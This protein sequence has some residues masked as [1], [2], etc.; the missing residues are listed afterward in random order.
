MQGNVYSAGKVFNTGSGMDIFTVKYSSS[1][2]ILWERTYNGPGN[3]NDIAHSIAV[4]KKGN[5][6]VGG[7]S[8]GLNTER[9]Y[10]LLKF[11]SQGDEQWVK[12]Y[13]GVTGSV[14]IISK[15]LIDQTGNPVV[16]GSSYELA[17]VSDIVT[18]K[19]D[20]DGNELW[21]SHFNGPA[22]GND[23]AND[24]KID[25][26][27]NIYVCGS[28]FGGVGINDF[29][30][31]KYN[32][33]G[34]EIWNRTYNG[35][36]NGNDNFTSLAI[37]ILGNVVITGSSVGS[38]T[39]IDFAT[40]KYSP[41]GDS[42]WTRR[43]N[44]PANSSHDEPKAIAMD[45]EG[46]VIITGTSVG[47]S[48][49]YDYLTVKY[50]SDGQELW[51]RRYHG[52]SSLAFDE[53]RSIV[54][55]NSGNSY[56]AGFSQGPAATDDMAIIKYDP[57]GNEMWVHRYSSAANRNDVANVV[58]LDNS[59][60]L[61]VSGF[62][63]GTASGN[64]FAVIKFS[65]LTGIGHNSIQ[66]P[67]S[68]SLSQNYPNPFNPSTSLDFTISN[69]GFVALKV[70]DVL[71]NEVSTMLNEFKHAGSY[72]TE[73]SGL[74]SGNQLPSGIYFYTLLVNGIRADTKRMMLLK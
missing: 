60:N 28:S 19:Y 8:K 11:N 49:S 35:P 46:N 17:T 32:I 3:A 65:L 59:G 72:K 37:D 21:R 41:L 74:T 15:V 31:I 14:D 34:V 52:L 48:T 40:V 24:M 9:D 42:L 12:R 5:V 1:G 29:I 57:S 43:Y 44:G 63:Q 16:T 39:A 10:V 33:N 73:F 68:A 51:A 66:F 69:A 7:E 6:Y 13:N 2:S 61:I 45:E 64:D 30:L 4:D 22:N 56:I 50:S 53:P 47:S 70:F 71:G 67:A 23:F 36:V 25:A 20:P 26:F 18:I 54:V 55:D 38:G 58:S 62:I 27:G